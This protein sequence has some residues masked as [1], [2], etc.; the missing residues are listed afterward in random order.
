M[1]IRAA[2]ESKGPSAAAWMELFSAAQSNTEL[3]I[4]W[5]AASTP[6]SAAILL[7]EAA[8]APG[9]LR[10][11]VPSLWQEQQQLQ[12]QRLAGSSWLATPAASDLHHELHAATLGPP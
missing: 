12:Q 6:G 4:A 3:T 2:G 5:S 9:L 11:R 10:Q 8:A 7:A 1:A